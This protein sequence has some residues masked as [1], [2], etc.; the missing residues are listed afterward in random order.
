MNN[1]TFA[2]HAG[3]AFD[4]Y[5]PFIIPDKILPG[6]QAAEVLADEL[7]IQFEVGAKKGG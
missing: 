1:E 5:K 4:I 6:F 7:L 2:D 3:N